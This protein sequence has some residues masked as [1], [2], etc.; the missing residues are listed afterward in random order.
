M[1]RTPELVGVAE[2]AALA[3]VPRNTAA[4]WMKRGKLPKP[5]VT[6]AMGPVWL[7][8]DITAWLKRRP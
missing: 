1:S 3:G 6:L 2:I 8:T 5:V 7:K 4:V